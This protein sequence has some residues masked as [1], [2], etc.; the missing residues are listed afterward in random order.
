MIVL[1]NGVNPGWGGGGGG[2]MQLFMVK[3]GLYKYSPTF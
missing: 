3:D 2:G 1:I